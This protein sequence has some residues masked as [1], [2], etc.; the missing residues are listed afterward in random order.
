[1]ALAMPEIG[2]LDP[3]FVGLMSKIQQL[4]RHVWQTQNQMT[5]PVSNNPAFNETKMT[6]KINLMNNNRIYRLAE[7]VVLPWRLVWQTWLSLVNKISICLSDRSRN[8]QNNSIG[9]TVVI[10]SAGYFAERL[11][12]M[13]TRYGANLITI[14]KPWGN[15]FPLDEIKSALE[16][17]KPKVM[18][19]IHAET[20]TGTQF[21]NSKMQFE[22]DG[23]LFFFKYPLSMF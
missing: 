3:V 11:C 15:I 1:M 14:K 5:I 4:L 16:T 9:D 13:A 22:R 2:H 7:R 18:G 8:D 6:E 17:H 21:F 23:R 10:F 19:I 20:S 12:D